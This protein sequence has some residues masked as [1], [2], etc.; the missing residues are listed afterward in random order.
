MFGL[1]AHVINHNPPN[2]NLHYHETGFKCVWLPRYLHTNW[3]TYTED[4]A[5]TT[6]S[7]WWCQV[8]VTTPKILQKKTSKCL[9]FIR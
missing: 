4:M 8:E 5:A 2:V 7:V 3:G 6:M 9:F 1:L